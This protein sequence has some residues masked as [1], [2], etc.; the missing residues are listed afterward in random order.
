[1]WML[2]DAYSSAFPRATVSQPFE[3]QSV[4]CHSKLSQTRGQ[5]LFSRLTHADKVTVGSQSPQKANFYCIYSI[6][7]TKMCLNKPLGYLLTP[8]ILYDNPRINY[9]RKKILGRGL[10]NTPKNVNFHAIKV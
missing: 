9:F 5:T 10:Y 3:W 2:Q 7:K 6:M 8:L 1:M 4:N